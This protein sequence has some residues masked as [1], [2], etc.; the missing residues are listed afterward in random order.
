MHS[1][2]EKLPQRRRLGPV[3]LIWFWTPR[4]RA[5]LNIGK[6]LSL[7][8]CMTPDHKRLVYVCAWKAGS[9]KNVGNLTW[10]LLE[11]LVTYMGLGVQYHHDIYYSWW[12]S[13]VMTDGKG[14]AMQCLQQQGLEHKKWRQGRADDTLRERE[15]EERREWEKE[16]TWMCRG[17]N[18]SECFYFRAKEDIEEKD[19]KSRWEKGMTVFMDE[20]FEIWIETW[21]EGKE[22]DARA[23]A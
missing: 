15:L 22:G 6:C 11:C 1:L 19:L 2:R 14:L 3:I 12:L 10:S 17:Q 5:I 18:K 16:E 23:S 9:F 4:V 13:L 20:T 8:F 7:C 21:H